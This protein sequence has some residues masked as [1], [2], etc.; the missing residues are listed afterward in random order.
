MSRGGRTCW[1]P[2][3]AAR[4]SPARSCPSRGR[5]RRS[6]KG[7]SASRRPRGRATALL[8]S[9]PLYGPEHPNRGVG[10]TRS[11]S[12]VHGREAARI[13][14]QRHSPAGSTNRQ[15]LRSGR[16]IRAVLGVVATHG[17]GSR[18]PL[19]PRPH[20]RLH[21]HHRKEL[22]HRTSRREPGR[23]LAFFEAVWETIT[24]RNGVLEG[25]IVQD[26][27]DTSDPCLIH[28]NDAHVLSVHVLA[29]HGAAPRPRGRRLG[30][31]HAAAP[32]LVDR[33]LL[34]L[35]ELDAGR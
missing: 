33:E 17:F 2:P 35:G 13:G 30:V 34:G 28:F 7:R 10:P 31:C 24:N 22:A 9:P 5:R 27:G 15:Q 19:P 32:D 12:S 20:A 8:D 16:C 18:R 29:C 4:P 11:S 21:Q 6:E 14:N 1:R 25:G 26:D 23:G 3:C